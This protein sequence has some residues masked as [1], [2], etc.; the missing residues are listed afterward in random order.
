MEILKGIEIKGKALWFKKQKVLVISDI[1]LGY[2]QTLVDSGILV[3]K[4]MFQDIKKEFLELLN[5]K[6][7]TIVING[8]L[9]HEFGRISK[10]EWK[11]AI[12]LLDLFQKES[13]VILIRGNHD[14]FLDPIAKK[15]KLDV[16]DFFIFDDVCVLHG[17]KIFLEA[18]D[19]Q[20]KTLV[21][22]HDHPAVSI[23]DGLKREKFKCFLL[24]KYKDKNLV[25]MPSFFN[26]VEGS[27][28]KR[29]RLFSPFLKDLKK[30]KVFALGDKAYDFGKVK[31]L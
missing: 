10:Q 9:K 14:M 7:K 28:I 11:D 21:I 24:G 22:G 6:P 13:E 19:K 29:E 25:V 27:D 8:D 5:L 16:R 2:E 26:L 12:E 3:P 17:D 18:L 15:K 23:E 30:F 1:H 4:S 31:D 20:I